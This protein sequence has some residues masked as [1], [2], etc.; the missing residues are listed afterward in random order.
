[1]RNIAN[2]WLKE[3]GKEVIKSYETVR[4]WGR[5]KNKRSI[6]SKQHRGQGLFSHRKPQK[7]YAEAHIKT[8]FIKFVN[9][10]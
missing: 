7:T 4:S 2:K 8:I 5:P 6:Q 3:N 9:V 10:Y 1:M